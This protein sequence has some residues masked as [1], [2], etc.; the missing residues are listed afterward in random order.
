[1]VSESNKS[2]CFIQGTLWLEIETN[3][4]WFKA[5][6]ILLKGCWLIHRI[7]RIAEESDLGNRQALREVTQWT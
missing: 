7:V 1:M 6:R 3:S 4:G 2:P 5:E